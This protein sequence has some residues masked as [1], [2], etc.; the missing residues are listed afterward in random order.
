[1]TSTTAIWRRLSLL[2]VAGFLVACGGVNAQV[3]QSA[4]CQY[5]VTNEWNTGLTAEIRIT[6]TGANAINGWSVNWQY[7]TNRISNS[8][9]ANITGNNPYAASNLSWNAQIPV[10]QTVA[11][12]LQVNKNGAIAELPAVTGGVCG[13]LA[14]SQASS[15]V[16][17]VASSSS[18]VVVSSSSSSVS[19]SSSSR[20]SSSVSSSVVSSASSSLAVVSSSSS[21]RASSVSSSVASSVMAC[22]TPRTDNQWAGASC[23]TQ[24]NNCVSGT[25]L[26]PRDGGETRAPLR[27]E[28]EHF[29]FYWSDGTNITMANAQA[30]SVTLEAI[31]DSYFGSPI[32]FPEP[33]C[34]STQKY[35][36]AVHFDN[37]F[38]LW[39]GGWSRNGINYMG[40]WVGPGAASD[41]WGLAHEFMHG[42]QAMT[43][44]F[45]DCG[46]VG[47][48]IYESHANWMP[49][50]IFNTNVHC[51]EMLVNMPHLYYGNT[52]NRYCN[53]Q[54]FEFIKDKYCHTAVNQMWTYNAPAGQRDPWQKLMLS[55][56][57]NIEQ[58]N[59]RFGEWA[60]HNVTWDYKSPNGTDQGNVYRQQYGAINSE[61]GNY[62]ARRLR[63]TQLEALDSNWAQNRRFA[64]PYYWAPQR[65]GY[66]V[67]QLFPEA[68]AANIQVKFR[69]VV[70][71]GANSGWRW[72]LVSTNAA[73]TQARY[74]ELQR[75]VDGELNL[76]ITPGENVFLVIVTT[77]T[78]YQK[79]TWDNPADGRAYPSIYRYP[80]MVEV[81]GAWPQGFR[82]GQRDACPNGTVRHSNGGGCAPASTPGS[83][84]VGPYAKI[85]GGSVTGSA[86]IEDQATVVNG[87]VSGG[88]VGALSLIGVASHPHHGASSFGVSGSARVLGTFYPLGWFGSNQ[89]VSGTATLLGDLEFIASSKTSNT[90]YGFVPNDWNGVSSVTEV[91][92]APPYTWR[93]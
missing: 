73:M 15:I 1:M 58:L 29:A 35:K 16:S 39:G 50:Q 24:V 49:H 66:N 5:V 80:Y 74:T 71:S 65:W 18:S 91:T 69:G 64:S 60:M 28:T 20:S 2:G 86:R 87:T 21:S 53:W 41:P 48:W 12:G 52:R 68:G 27:L 4:S 88:T 3:S 61:P 46:G 56:S 75:G 32:Y 76:C 25:W 7:A 82:N 14:S 34:N 85:L 72:G 84:Y 83:V 59:D 40:M 11:F 70:Q 67:I 10:G 89:S 13:S 22:V 37:Q 8:W 6:N 9:N 81:Q 51:S 33:Y 17:S 57:W 36:A 42:V 63:L 47:C 62:T 23:A 45:G 55:Q 19:V 93:P 92:I 90:F 54:F 26:A 31:W 79:I 44:G 43:Q 30:A 77:P 78:Q 38:P